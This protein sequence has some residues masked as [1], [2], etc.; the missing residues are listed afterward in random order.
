[1][2]SK[3]RN[4]LHFLNSFDLII[5]C[6]LFIIDFCKLALHY[7]QYFW[8]IIYMIF[9]SKKKEQQS[10]AMS[11]AIYIILYFLGHLTVSYPNLSNISFKGIL[12]LMMQRSDVIVNPSSLNINK[13]IF[14][15]FCYKRYILLTLKIFHNIN[16]LIASIKFNILTF[17]S[18]CIKQSY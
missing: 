13:K 18:K 5:L 16:H 6:H 2:P 12:K 3:V 17:Q 10:H 11:N 15:T 8:Q 7:V 1:M 9:C 14:R 4:K